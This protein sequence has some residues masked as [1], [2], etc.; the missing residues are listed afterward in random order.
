VFESEDQSRKSTTPLHK[1]YDFSEMKA[2]F[3]Q[4]RPKDETRP[5]LKKSEQVSPRNKDDSFRSWERGE[6]MERIYL[7]TPKESQPV[8]SFSR[9]EESLAKLNYTPQRPDRFSHFSP[10]DQEKQNPSPYFRERNFN[11]PKDEG[12]NEFKRES[13]VNNEFKRESFNNEFKREGFLSNEFKREGFSNNEFRNREDDDRGEGINRDDLQM[14][15]KNRGFDSAQKERY[16]PSFENFNREDLAPRR[17][18]DE[19]LSKNSKHFESLLEKYKEPKKDLEKDEAENWKIDQFRKD[20]QGRWKDSIENERRRILDRNEDKTFDAFKGRGVN[21]ESEGNDWKARNRFKEENE[22]WKVDVGRK[23]DVGKWRESLE[24]E[25]KR[26]LERNDEKITNEGRKVEPFRSEEPGKWKESLENERN[27]FLEKNEENFSN[28]SWKTEGFRNEEI[29]KWRESMENERKKFLDKSDEKGLE[30]FRFR[31]KNDEFD[32][33]R[34]IKPERSEESDSF[35]RRPPQ[36]DTFDPSRYRLREERS[37]INTLK[38]EEKPSDSSKDDPSRFKLRSEDYFE[39]KSKSDLLE[40]FRREEKLEDFENMRFRLDSQ[41]NSSKPKFDAQENSRVRNEDLRLRQKEEKQEVLFRPEEKNSD[42]KKEES[43]WLKYR[44]D[45]YFDQKARGEFDKFRR[46]E[47]NEEFENLRFR[48]EAQESASKIREDQRTRVEEN[49]R[50]ELRAQDL[51]PSNE[52]D[53]R[54]K[55]S[56]RQVKSFDSAEVAQKYKFLEAEDFSKADDSK[57]RAY[58]IESPAEGKLGRDPESFSR[59]EEA[60]KPRDSEKRA[61]DSSLSEWNCAKC[62]KKVSGASYECAECRLINWD[63]FYKVKSLQHNRGRAEETRNG[64]KDLKDSEGRDEAVRRLYSFSDKKEE[65]DWVCAGCATSNKS[66]FF[67]CKGCRKPKTMAGGLKE[68]RFS[69]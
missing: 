55:S 26:L 44:T 62:S 51:N 45:N 4:N 66:L 38:S 52:S 16:R 32:G 48:I 36:Q 37:E 42:L 20:D 11:V 33:L 25:R 27:R 10:K 18:P 29:K 1:K 12:K 64:D 39:P 21:E 60:F 65:D 8:R 40:K 50:S 68:A 17:D 13:Y 34:D 47:N 3:R 58:R 59:K 61:D 31:A 9:Q 43:P 23:D 2:D 53:S 41:E 28:E 19:S 63:Q 30:N 5:S 14:F 49:F 56:I 22:T 15:E 46:E 7:G 35:H 57:S 24:N 67:L 6:E 54:E 69:S